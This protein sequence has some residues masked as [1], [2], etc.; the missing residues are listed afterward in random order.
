MEDGVSAPRTEVRLQVLLLVHLPGWGH[1]L[2]PAVLPRQEPATEPLQ[3]TDL[4]VEAPDRGLELLRRTERP[5]EVPCHRDG[6][7]PSPH[8]VQ[9]PQHGDDAADHVP[10]EEA[11]AA[12]W[13]LRALRQVILAEL[14]PHERHPPLYQRG[15]VRDVRLTL[16]VAVARRGAEPVEALERGLDLGRS[17]AVGNRCLLAPLVAALR[18][19]ALALELGLP[20]PDLGLLLLRLV[21]P[22]LAP[23]L[24]GH[25]LL[26]PTP[27]RLA[28]RLLVGPHV[29]DPRVLV[30]EG[31]GRPLLLPLLHLGK[32]ANVLV[33]DG[34]TAGAEAQTTCLQHGHVDGLQA[35]GAAATHLQGIQ[36]R[37]LA[38]PQLELP[39]HPELTATLQP[40]G[41]ALSRV[42][43]LAGLLAQPALPL[44]AP[45]PLLLGLPRLAEALLLVGLLLPA[46][47][48]LARCPLHGLPLALHDEE[49]LLRLGPQLG[50]VLVGM[51]LQLQ[52]PQPPAL[53]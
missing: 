1:R 38:V 7:V 39:R 35:L 48:L 51:Q 36:Q 28:A 13:L 25:G 29:V 19:R 10:P 43:R 9:K 3:G 50:R 33:P 27:D 37:Y 31:G 17:L 32:H 49:E 26:G 30:R 14:L 18:G 8:E 11:A 47:L 16:A 40:Q 42:L 23:D 24:G 45:A 20:A 15:P 4:E 12:C 22:L 6:L 21:V 2:A 46:P 53:L 52:C 5:A 34:A 41:D 44:C